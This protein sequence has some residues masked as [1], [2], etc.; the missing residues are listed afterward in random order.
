MLVEGEPAKLGARAFDVLL[1]LVERR[2]RVISKNELLDIVW[3]GLVVEENN[4]Q[5]H[6]SALRKLLGPM[7]IDTI[8]GRGYRFTAA[9]DDVAPPI[10][11]PTPAAAVSDRPP[12]GNL[13]D[14]IPALFGRD[15]DVSALMS[16]VDAHRLVSIVGAG[17]DQAKIRTNVQWVCARNLRLTAATRLRDT[18]RGVVE[19]PVCAARQPEHWSKP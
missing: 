10:P 11:M 9:P 16:L 6:I 1:S 15:E 13:P 2:E 7:V 18:L 12:L 5:V 17:S 4:L 8:P 14:V 3:P 19:L